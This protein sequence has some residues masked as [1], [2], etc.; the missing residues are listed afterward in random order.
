MT[1]SKLGLLIEPPRD[2]G[3]WATSHAALPHAEP[4]ENGAVAVYFST[5]DDLNRASIAR[6]EVGLSAHVPDPLH[7][8]AR[9]VL[10]P[11][12]LGAFDDAGVTSSCLVDWRGHRHL[13]Y[14]GWSR[15]SSV[16]F[17]FYIGCA[18]SV[19]GGA[20]FSR[21]SEAPILERNHVD[22]YLTAS[23]SILI[24]SGTWR[25]WYVTGT[26]W[27]A[28]SGRLEPCYRI[29]YAESR[30]GIEWRRD[31]RV[32]IDYSEPEEHAISRP[33]VVRDASTYRMWFASRGAS[34]RI[35]Y[36]E[37]A[38]GFEWRRVP[39][40]GGVE[41]SSAG[42]DSEMVCYPCVFDHGGSRYMLYNG[43]GYGRS[44]IGLARLRAEPA[45]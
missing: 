36:A 41:P 28:A 17:Y 37:S 15:G 12:S 35:R 11:G 16:P 1:W 9:P 29:A 22:P 24:E 27:R 34:Y 20:T 5:R 2:I 7:Q 44:G 39:E 30:D 25:M 13:Y 18:I 23:P 42:W 3:G 31:G 45:D 10:S 21:V 43:N 38:D 26:G 40:L 4:A 8:D 32:C 19:D 33:W 6:A 14:S